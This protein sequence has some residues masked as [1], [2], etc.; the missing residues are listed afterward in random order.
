MKD[1]YKRLTI[2]SRK[3]QRQVI[4]NCKKYTEAL[5]EY[6]TNTEVLIIEG[7]KAIVNKIGVGEKVMEASE[8][9]LME[10]GLAQTIVFIQSGLRTKVK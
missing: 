5:M 3:K 1:E 9:K 10:S 2:E 4:G 6:L 8:V 7:Q